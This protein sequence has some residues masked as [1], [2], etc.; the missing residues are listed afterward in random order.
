MKDLL[1]QI[2]FAKPLFLWLL[3]AVPLLWFRFRV[4]RPAVII[5]RT[6]VLLLLIVTLADP[7]WV[8][9]QTRTDEAQGEERI[10]AFDLSKSIPTS[11]RRWMDGVAQGPLAPNRQDRVFVFASDQVETGDWRAWLKGEGVQAGAIRPEK[12]NLEKLLTG[13][14]ALPAKPRRLFLFTDGW[15]TEGNLERLLPAIA[16]A[17]IKI[18]PIVPTERPAINNVAVAKIVA[19][20][21]GNSGEAVNLRIVLENQSDHEI[22]GTLALS[23]GGQSLKSESVK[24]RPGSHLFTY[25][26]ILPESSLTSYGATFT[27][28]RAE[29]DGNS[30]DNQ[31]LAWVTVQSKA[32]VLLLNGR[33][34]GGRYLEQI[35]KRQGFE[36]TSSTAE[37]P[38]APAGHSVVIFNNVEREKLSSTYLAAIERHV[39]EGNGFLMVGNEASFAPGAYRRTPIEALLPVEPREPRKEEKNRAIVL[40]IDKS[41][42]MRDEN[43]LLYAQEAARAVARQLKDTDLLGVVGFDSSPFVVVPLSP[44]AALRAGVESQISRLKPGGRTYLLPA[45]VEAKRQIERQN[46]STKHVIILS[47]GETGGSGGDYVDLVNVMKTELKVTVSTVAIG[48]DA[49]IPLMK[50]IS[51]YGGGF[52]HHTFDPKSLPQIVLQQLQDKPKDEPPAERDFLPLQERGSELLAGGV[53]KYPTVRGNMD[54]DLKR[55]AKLDLSISRDDRKSPLLASWRY[56]KGKSAALTMDLEGRWSKNWIQWSGLQ[57][58]WDKALDWLRPGVQPIPAHEARVSFLGN[59][60]IMDLYVYDELSADSQFRFSVNGKGGRTDGAFKK[61]APGHFQAALPNTPPGDYRIDLTEERSSRRLAYPSVGYTLPYGANSEQPRLEFNNQLLD[62][63]AQVSGGEINPKL[64]T[65]APEAQA[66]KSYR[67]FRNPLI[68]LVF[69]LFLLEIAFRRLLLAE[70]A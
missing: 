20:A 66:T 7:Q 23:R 6:F 65:R 28:R 58:F 14:M 53:E 8:A 54:T 15:E 67:P 49:N 10:F 43:R 37:T 62:K 32:K 64:S 13:I 63:L 45:I 42:S 30:V 18:F 55:G 4:H 19:P 52:F 29:S 61:L 11:M 1:T 48:S 50:R 16:S 24:L 40:V 25:Q 26:V 33:A 44:M 35:L 5:W 69:A 34:G 57:N 41:G 17:G 68:G 56:G 36:V 21:H 27:P 59:Q 46:A 60:P 47:D 51:Q 12:T 38:P 31:A 2:H 70:T 39:A 3:L 22:D 9:E